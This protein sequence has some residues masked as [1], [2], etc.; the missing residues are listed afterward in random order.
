[1]P[2][3]PDTNRGLGHGASLWIADYGSPYE[4]YHYAVSDVLVWKRTE[5]QTMGVVRSPLFGKALILDGKWQSCTADEFLYHEPL[6]HPAMILHGAPKRVAI[7]G[8]GEGA[9]AREV[10]RWHSVERVV[11]IDIDGQVVNECRRH[12]DEMHQGA[13]DDPRLEL[14]IG[15][16]VDW[17]KTVDERFDVVI[18]DLSEPVEQGPSFRLFTREYFAETRRVLEPR[19]IFVL[20]AGSVSPVDITLHARLIRTLA[21]VFEHVRPF[22]SAVPSFAQP[23]GFALASSLPLDPLPDPDAVDTIVAECINGPLEMLDGEAFIG[24]FMVP[25]HIRRAIDREHTVYT[26][27]QP[28]T[29]YTGE[30]R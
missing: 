12:L 9:T 20:Q 23:W 10:L 2:Q 1:M 26:L 3:T 17:L 7:L 11:M 4:A 30:T 15:D 8:G 21:A 6:V 18:S 25:A 14:I 29:T 24:L 22:S 13:F 19:G 16:A 28:P 27:E 5:Y